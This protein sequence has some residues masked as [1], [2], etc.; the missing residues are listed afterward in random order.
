LEDFELH[1]YLPPKQ[2]LV[3]KSPFMV[4]VNEIDAFEF[5]HLWYVDY[6]GKNFIVKQATSEEITKLRR[7]KGSYD[8]EF[9]ELLIVC[10]EAYKKGSAIYK[11]HCKKI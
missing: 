11:E 7:L 2:V 10:G 6:V 1:N 5:S 4:T 8:K 3:E 9:K